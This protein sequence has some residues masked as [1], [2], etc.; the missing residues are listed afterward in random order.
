MRTRFK[1]TDIYFALWFCFFCVINNGWGQSLDVPKWM[2]GDFWNVDVILYSRGWRLAFSDPKMEQEKLKP[3][4]FARYTMKIEVTAERKHGDTDCWQLDFTPSEK[5]KTPRSV[6]GQK[7]R[8]LVAKE[9]GSIKEIFRISGENLGNPQQLEDVDGITV[10]YKA[11]YGFPLEIIPWRTNKVEKVK[12]TVLTASKSETSVGNEKHR[13]LIV[14]QGTNEVPR[15]IQKWEKGAKW[16]SEYERYVSGHI[17]LQSKL[18]EKDSQ[19]KNNGGMSQNSTNEATTNNLTVPQLS[20][21]VV[22]Q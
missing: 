6:H 16:W 5:D 7:Y 20:T 2:V 10:V 22:T 1:L 17:E 19:D 18:I 4:V 13:E 12:K 8:I 3:H 15:I 21:N 14:K 9:D 11:P